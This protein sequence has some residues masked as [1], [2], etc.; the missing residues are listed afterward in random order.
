MNIFEEMRNVAAQKR[1]AELENQRRAAVE[2]LSKR[3]DFPHAQDCPRK[4]GLF[5]D[6][7]R[8]SVL[9]FMRSPIFDGQP[10]TLLSL[11]CGDCGAQRDVAE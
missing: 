5:I 1:A 6:A 11:T 9:N 10:V 8:S 3:G 2:R 4:S 7:G